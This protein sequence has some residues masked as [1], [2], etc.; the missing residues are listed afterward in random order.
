M[1]GEYA[2]GAGANTRAREPG[3]VVRRRAL[4]AQRGFGGGH[5]LAH[6]VVVFRGIVAAS[7]AAFAISAITSG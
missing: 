6:R 5:G 1:L 2:P 3:G 4:R 7:C